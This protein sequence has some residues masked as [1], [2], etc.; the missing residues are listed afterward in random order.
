MPQTTDT[1]LLSA[2]AFDI[3]GHVC[4][5]ITAEYRRYLSEYSREVG[6]LPWATTFTLRRFSAERT[7]RWSPSTLQIVRRAFRSFYRWASEQGLCENVAAR[8]A[9]DQSPGMLPG[10]AS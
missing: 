7:D 8:V 2:W 6:P 3:T 5:A 4:P 9:T 10:A 1:D